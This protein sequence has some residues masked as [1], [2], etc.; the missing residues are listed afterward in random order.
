MTIHQKKGLFALLFL[1]GAGF[2][3]AFLLNAGSFLRV[4]EHP[5]LSDAIVVLSPGTERIETGVKLWKEGYADD[6][7]L[8]R[9]NTGTFTV[10]EAVAQGVPKDHVIA[11][12]QAH[13]TYTNATYTKKLL[14]Q[15]G[16]TSAIIVT[17]D[18]HM[19]RT[20]FIFEKVFRKSGIS[21]SYAPTPSHYNLSAWWNDPE[22]KRMIWKEYAKLAG[23][24][25][26]Y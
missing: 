9:A 15:R 12:E 19:R 21:L 23:Y 18:Y 2:L 10:G 3:A 4:D 20:Q 6:V 7:V 11:E 1:S 26:L 14:Q 22:S 13:S 8:S 25:I 16:S 5:V 17:S 24:Y